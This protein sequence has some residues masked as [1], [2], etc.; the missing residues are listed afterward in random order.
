MLFVLGNNSNPKEKGLGEGNSCLI[1]SVVERKK[2]RCLH[3][4][5]ELMNLL[6]YHQRNSCPNS[7]KKE[8]CLL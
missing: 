8:R 4:E 3:C 6:L 7:K 5:P 2:E 1:S